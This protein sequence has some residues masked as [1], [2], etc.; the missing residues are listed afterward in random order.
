MRGSHLELGNQ[1]PAFL[2]YEAQGMENEK[3]AEGHTKS[4]VI[5]ISL[6]GTDLIEN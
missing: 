5:L 4:N 1:M 2:C 6:I 3:F